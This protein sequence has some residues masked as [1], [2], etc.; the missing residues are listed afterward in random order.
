MGSVIPINV[1]RY[2]QGVSGGIINIL[3]DGSIDFSE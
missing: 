1:T 3:G 2:T